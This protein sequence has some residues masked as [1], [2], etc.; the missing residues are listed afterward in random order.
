MGYHSDLMVQVNEREF[1]SINS[2]VCSGCIGDYA[3]SEFIQNNAEENYCDYCDRTA[4]RPIALKMEEVLEFINQGVRRE[5]SNPANAGLP[6]ETREGGWQGE[7]ISSYELFGAFSS[8]DLEIDN[9]DLLDDIISAFSDQ[10]WSD[11]EPYRLSDEAIYYYS[12]E[13][14]CEAVKHKTRYVFS[15]MDDESEHDE[16]TISVSKMLEALASIIRDSNLIYSIPKD[17]QIYRVRIHDYG[18]GFVTASELGSPPKEYAIFPNRMSPSGIAMFYGGSDPNTAI[19]ETYDPLKKP[20]FA[21]SAEFR[22]LREM[23]ILDLSKLNDIPS[24]FDQENY[25]MRAAS[26]FLRRFSREV[27]KSIS[28]DGKEHIEY[29]P[30]QVFAEY[31]RHVF[32]DKKGAALDG[33]M[34][35]S[36]KNHEG[37]NY[38]LFAENEQ[39]RDK[40]KELLSEFEYGVPQPLLVLH[41]VDELNPQKVLD[42]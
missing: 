28:K 21:S 32:R 25:H 41:H 35:K 12:W 11:A 27:S 6:Y 23:N 9:Q 42:D 2:S 22:S 33:V 30:T 13:A 36:S 10:E 24:L 34:Y 37:I 3:I 4:N 26:I 7:V 29:V 18:K 40:G 39:C 1:S 8:I 31:M 15:Q 14:F 5:W 17:T 16:E 20:E 19:Q 38:V